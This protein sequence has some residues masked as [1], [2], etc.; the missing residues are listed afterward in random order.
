VSFISPSAFALSH[1][2]EKIRREQERKV[3]QATINQ[4]EADLLNA[5]QQ[6]AMRR[7]AMESALEAERASGR[8]LSM[9]RLPDGVRD[10]LD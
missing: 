10:A 6:A 2:W 9:C 8:D 5:N 1:E 7:R 3:A 4:A